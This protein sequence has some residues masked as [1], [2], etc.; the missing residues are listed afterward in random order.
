MAPGHR[1]HLGR[2]MFP[3]D[4]HAQALELDLLLRPVVA[5]EDRF[6]RQDA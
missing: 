6:V 3:A 5:F 2:V 4:R 1:P